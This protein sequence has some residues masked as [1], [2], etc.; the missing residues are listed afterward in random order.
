MDQ[1]S[2]VVPHVLALEFH[3]VPHLESRDARRDIDVMVYQERLPRRQLHD[4]ALVPLAAGVVGQ[5]LLHRPLARDFDVALVV[6]EGFRKDGV[7]RS[8]RS[9][10][11]SRGG[12]GRRRGGGT[13]RD[14]R[15]EKANSQCREEDGGRYPA[16]PPEGRLRVLVR[17]QW[18]LCE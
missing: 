2:L 13:A 17:V 14:R 6:G 16:P 1:P 5:E 3:G 12:A 10:R 9:R 7:A 11:V 8:G 15:A 4:E 18:G